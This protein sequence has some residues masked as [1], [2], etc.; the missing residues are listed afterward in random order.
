MPKDPGIF[1][2]YFANAYDAL[3]IE[4]KPE[5]LKDNED[6]I[7]RGGYYA[8]FNPPQLLDSLQWREIKRNKYGKLYI[9]DNY[10][11]ELVEVVKTSDDDV[12]PAVKKDEVHQY[13]RAVDLGAFSDWCVRVPVLLAPYVIETYGHDM[14]FDY[15]I[16]RRCIINFGDID[17][18]DPQSLARLVDC[19]ASTRHAIMDIQSKH[20]DFIVNN[21]RSYASCNHTIFHD[22][23]I[24]RKRV[25]VFGDV[26][27]RN[28][29][30]RAEEYKNEVES[31]IKKR[32][33]VRSSLYDDI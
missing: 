7:K 21:V 14:A 4:I 30:S 32:I 1:Y 10:G 11:L 16:R 2:R 8:V 18:N 9:D 6:H 28:T 13:G 29:Y 3:D 31:R 12:W 26:E 25:V 5:E 19:A 17:E 27:V 33:E 22:V 15:P 24:V 20:W 23:S